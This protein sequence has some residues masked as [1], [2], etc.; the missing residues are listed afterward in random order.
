MLI[1][2]LAG[3]QRPDLA[4]I[5]MPQTPRTMQQL[6]SI[7]SVA[8][9]TLTLT[10]HR[11]LAQLSV[12]VANLSKMEDRMMDVLSNKRPPNNFRINTQYQRRPSCNYCDRHCFENV[13]RKAKR[14]QAVSI[15]NRSV[16]R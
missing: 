6:R 4:G 15:Q 12:Q 5:V 2:M 16:Q 10:N 11:P 14:N 3:G 1:D 8:E 9:K 13:C 7:A